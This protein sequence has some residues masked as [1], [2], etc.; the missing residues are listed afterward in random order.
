MN[1]ASHP[2]A[3][4][5]PNSPPATAS[6]PATPSAS[7]PVPTR[8]VAIPL[9]LARRA[10]VAAAIAGIPMQAYIARAI[11]AELDRASAA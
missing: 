1:S 3:P 4:A 10:K 2:P 7:P 11:A 8:N 6:S 5:V 9:E